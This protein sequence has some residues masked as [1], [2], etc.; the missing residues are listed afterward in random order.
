MQIEEAFGATDE[1]R[2]GEQ[3]TPA[4]ELATPSRERIPTADGDNGFLGGAGDV[5]TDSEVDSLEAA[6]NEQ[7]LANYREFQDVPFNFTVNC[8]IRLRRGSTQTLKWS[9]K[10]GDGQWSGEDQLDENFEKIQVVVK[11]T[12]ARIH[13]Q[14]ATLTELSREER[15][16][17]VETIMKGM[18]QSKPEPMIEVS[19]EMLTKSNAPLAP[20]TRQPTDNVGALAG[21]SPRRTRT[22]QQEEQVRH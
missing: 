21:R 8:V 9:N 19:I 22:V 12:D 5:E 20:P 11:S 17:R 10:I 15:K 14:I 2:A 13:R 1:R 3:A 16:K 18:C 4:R 6:I 7:E